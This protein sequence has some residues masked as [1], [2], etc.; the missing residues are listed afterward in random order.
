MAIQ[1]LKAAHIFDGTRMHA[2]A[3]V[4]LSAQGRILGLH[5]DGDA[6]P[7]PAQD[8]GAGILAPGLVDVQ[9]NGGAGV[10]VGAGTDAGQLARICGAHARLGA[11]AI[12][13]TLITDTPDV[14]RQVIAAGLNA[15]RAGVAGFAGLHLEGPHL[16]PARKGAH[17]AGLIR[18][19]NKDD[20]AL[21]C[22]AAQALPALMITLAPE[23][24][25]HAQIAALAEAGAIVSL[26]HSG[27]DAATALAAHRAGARSVTHLYNAMGAL[28]NR[29]PGLLGAALTSPLV[30]GIIADGVHVAPECMAVALQMK[31]PDGLYLVSDSMGFAGTD[32]REITLGG[33]RIL[34]ADGRLT[35]ADGT[36]AGADISLPQSL[37]CLA[38]LGV[39]AA[40]ALSMATRIP[41]DLIG[42]T[43]R[44]RITQGARADLVL[45][46][47]DWS[48]RAVWQAGERVALGEDVREVAG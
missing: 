41:A 30:A 6:L 37:A 23:A 43:D 47:P 11:C 7:A 16:D 45:L 28:Q 24:A 32:L 39:E 21:L 36:L 22:D 13:P 33:R 46:S 48:L 38:G 34:R 44:G 20:L 3:A 4:S 1:V 31:A 27:C 15:A 29:A 14:T 10:M 8:L 5:A 25:T 19:M 26:G 17:D 42:A 2:N 9:V 18:P 35:L 40:R 12:L